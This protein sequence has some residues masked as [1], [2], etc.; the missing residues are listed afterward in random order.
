MADLRNYPFPG[1]PLDVRENIR[2]RGGRFPQW[3]H[4]T[5]HE[6]GCCLAIEVK[7]VFMDEWSGTINEHVFNAVKD[8]LKST[9]PGLL[10]ELK[11]TQ[12]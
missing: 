8:A 1:R 4:E 7:K 3:V 5:F 6:T 9:L 2:F 11:N 10:E 12:R